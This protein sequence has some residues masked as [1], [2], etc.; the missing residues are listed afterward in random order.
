MAASKL[1]IGMVAMAGLAATASALKFPKENLILCDCGI[2]DNKEH[3]DWSTSR[4]MNWYQDISWPQLAYSYPEAPDMAVQVP[5]K[6]GIYPWVPTGATATMP[7]GNVWS[8]YIEDGTPDGFKAGSAVTTKEGGQMLNCWAYRGRPVSASINKTVNHDAVC[9]SAFVCNR[10]NH[11]P[12]RPKDMGSQTSSLTTASAAPTTSYFSQ[13]PATPIPFTSPGKPAPTASPQ[14]G[15]LSVS[16]TVS[17]R[18]I[19]WPSSWQAFINHFVW[20]KSTG[21][22]VGGPIQG[23]GYTIAVDCSGIQVDED[24]HMTLLLIKAL[25]DVGLNSLWFNQNPTIPS[26]NGTIPASQSWVVMPEVFTLH[27]TDA[28]TGNVVGHLSYKTHYDGFLE[29]PCSTCETARF[30]GPFFNSIIAAVQGSYPVYYNFTVDAR[31]D[32]WMACV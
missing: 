22:C 32:P 21:R 3:P 25:R 24:T 4:Q 1:T 17:P 15:T 23:A 2:G 13:V 6:D 19:N 7:N 5:F 18:F 12:P 28:A 16:S 14:S 29:G 27:A 31:C 30:N 9:W 8:A 20:D 10:D 26:N 11:P